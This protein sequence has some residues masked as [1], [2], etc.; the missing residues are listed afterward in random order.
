MMNP[1][2]TNVQTFNGTASSRAAGVAVVFLM[3]V[4][5]ACTQPLANRTVLNEELGRAQQASGAPATGATAYPLESEQGGEPPPTTNGDGTTL[6]LGTGVFTGANPSAPVVAAATESD[7]IVLNFQNADIQ[8]VVKAI[9]GDMLGEN[10]LVEQGVTG[11]VTTETSGGVAKEDLLTILELLLRQTQATL[12]KDGDLYRVVPVATSLKGSLSPNA[13]RQRDDPSFGLQ[14]VTLR[15]IAV[16]EMQKIL[17][18]ILRENALVHTNEKRNLIILAGTPTEQRRYL[19][20]IAIFD[21]D[22]MAGMSTALFKLNFVEPQQIAKEI[23]Q[24]LGGD[25]GKVMDGLVRLVPLERLNSLLAISPS[26]RAITEM[27]SWVRRLDAASDTADPRLY[28]FRL[29]NA[30]AVDVAAIL[31]DVFHG[32]SG[33]SGP[34]EA[35]LAPGLRPA[36]LSSPDEEGERGG[37]SSRSA[38]VIADEGVSLRVGENVRIIPDETNNGLVIMAT[39]KEYEIILAAIRKLDLIPLQVLIEATIIE[40]TLGDSLE[41]GVEWFF[42]NGLAGNKQGSGLLDLGAPGIGTVAPAFSYAVID[43]LGDVRAAIN[44]LATESDVSVLSSP[45][46]MVL[47]NQTATINVGDEIPVPTR[48]SISNI[49]PAAPTVNEIEY[50]NTGVTLEVTPRVNAGGLVTMEVN[51]EVSD[52]VNTTSSDLNAP[53]I[54]QRKITSTVA[55]QSGQ[56]IV[57]GGL[58]RDNATD[59]QSGI[60]YL[61]NLP[62]LGKLFSSTT[63]ATRRTELI[64]LITPRA[65]RN[66]DEA[67]DVTREYSEKMR[68]FDERDGAALRY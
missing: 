64:V 1:S 68:N 6:E 38:R 66:D 60:P 56:T 21:V 42:K 34:R 46:L 31:N 9:L 49:D 17:E 20:T 43:S 22:W 63:I 39:P 55:V 18:P 10:Y 13:G 5:S 57:L 33:N 37:P 51:Q 7:G 59:A 8:E 62:G 41:Y 27:Q 61:R 2:D 29:Q 67:R 28:V 35:E 26:R 48:A 58:I 47:D 54:Q 45:S 30:K 65:V 52:A 36:T 32:E 50:R 44:L 14:I 23:E 11:T 3:I 12:I 16:V 40:V 15:Y 53:T 4:L 24:A 19:D 25:G